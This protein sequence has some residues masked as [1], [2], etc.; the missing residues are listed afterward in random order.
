[1]KNNEQVQK[2]ETF[3]FGDVKVEKQMNYL[4]P[5]RYLLG[6]TEAKYVKAE[7]VKQDGSKKNSYLEVTFQGNDGK[8]STKMYV[9][10]NAF[11]RFQYLY[12]ALFNR[13]CTEE[14]SSMDAVGMFFEKA[15]SSATAKKIQKNMIV[16]GRGAANG[17]TYAEVPFMYF[18]IED[19]TDFK[20]GPFEHNS[21]DWFKYVTPAQVTPATN[22]DSV[23]IDSPWN[24]SS[25]SEDA[26]NDLPF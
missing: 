4:Q 17:K 19:G 5:G 7:G 3:N 18:I 1:M 24:D 6:I 2:G 21:A 23:M 25:A 13:E 8:V 15:F 9:T 11:K 12:M 22:T 14:F 20:Q 16:G 10:P 26:I